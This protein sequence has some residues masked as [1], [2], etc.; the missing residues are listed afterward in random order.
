[1]N[2]LKTQS[3]CFRWCAMFDT[4]K[5]NFF[6]DENMR[7]IWIISPKVNDWVLFWEETG[8]EIEMWIWN[9]VRYA[10]E[11][12]KWDIWILL[13]DINDAYLERL[14]NLWKK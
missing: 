2:F 12:V 9:A 10:I 3:W 4:H 1:M 7:I 13:K 5:G 14:N 8:S 11:N 6:L